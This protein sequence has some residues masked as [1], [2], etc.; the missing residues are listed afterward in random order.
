MGSNIRTL[1]SVKSLKFFLENSFRKMLVAQMILLGVCILICSCILPVAPI[2]ILFLW[3]VPLLSHHR[4]FSPLIEELANRGHHI[5]AYTTV[6]REKLPPN[7]TEII[8]HPDNSGPKMGDFD[9]TSW[10]HK[11]NFQYLH[12]MYTFFG[13][14]VED[15]L[16][17]PEL[18]SLIR[19]NEKFDLVL[20]EF[21]F[22]QECLSAFGHKFS[23]SVINLNPLFASPWLAQI[24]GIPHSFSYIPDFRLPYTD[25]MNFW[26]RA[27]NA[28]LGSYEIAIGNLIFMPFHDRL[29]RK[30]F[31]YPGSTVK[32]YPPLKDL[33]ANISLHLLDS[34]P[35][36]SSVRPY[37]PNVIDVGGMHIKTAG[38][39]PQ[40]LQTFMDEAAEGFIYFSFG[41]YI[42]GGKLP[43]RVH[44]IFAETLKGLKQRVVW[45][46]NQQIEGGAP[47]ILIR[48]WLPQQEILSHP[49]C[50]LFITHGGF[51]SMIEVMNIGVPVLGVPFFSDQYHNVAVYEHM[52]VGLEL[53]LEAATVPYIKEKINRI[54]HTPAFKQNAK[55]IAELFKDQPETSLEKALFWVEYVIRHKGAHH[56][57]P[58]SV[59]L[60]YYQYLLLDVIV[61][62]IVS[63]SIVAYI[64]YSAARIFLSLFY[65][66]PTDVKSKRK[67]E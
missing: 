31:E 63:L 44:Q 13:R 47:N 37:S 57:K 16:G 58:A 8:I 48:P 25:K 18:K 26:Q 41:S 56:L 45:K 61:F 10:R 55:R 34:H 42:D 62:G 28:L 7:Y 12:E 52:G 32:S 51:N 54:I 1:M 2:K 9:L 59:K 15:A 27:K 23:A 22:A 14:M 3:P 30:F 24:A 29:V 36:V 65:T 60:S 21:T 19:S 20:A 35:L 5:T 4:A 40:D 11:N 53:D 6:K 43:K 39:L 46:W 49:N 38:K 66:R 64:L 50:R 17:S 33:M 67:R